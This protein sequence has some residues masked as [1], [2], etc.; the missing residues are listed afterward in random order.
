MFS[1]LIKNLDLHRNL[2]VV[3]LMLIYNHPQLEATNFISN[4]WVDKP[5]M[6]LRIRLPMQEVWIWSLGQEDSLEK[7]IATYSTIPAWEIPWTEEP[8]RLQSM[9]S[10]K[11]HDLAT[12]KQEEQ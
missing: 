8:D 6:G 3:F 5:N 11:S 4:L 12:K 7:E 10:Q 1:W 2:Q 9:G